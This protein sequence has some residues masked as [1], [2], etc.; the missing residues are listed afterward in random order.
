MKK[1]IK[2]GAV[3]IS[4]IMLSSVFG[5]SALA[6][7]KLL[8]H[9]KF[10]FKYA[11]EMTKY[12]NEYREMNGLK[13]LKTDFTLVE[14]AMIRAAECG[15]QFSHTRPNTK[16]WST[17]VD[18]EGA[19]AENIARGFSNPKEA[20]DA[21]YNSDGHRTNMLG[22]YTRVGV[23]VFTAD[24]GTNSWIH[25]FTRGS[26]KNSYESKE[27]RAVNVSIATDPDDN[28]TVQ[29][30]DGKDTPSKLAYNYE[31]SKAPDIK[32][33]EISDNELEY[34]GKNQAPEV[35]ARDKNGKK[36]ERR[37][38]KIILPKKHSD[39][40]TYKITV[41]HKYNGKTFSRKYKIVPKATSIT[42]L[43]K[44]KKYI[45]VR[46]KCAAMSVTG[47]KICYA[48]NKRFNNKKTITLKRNKTIK[49]SPG[50][51]KERRTTLR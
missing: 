45:T 30:C 19:V 29:Y 36:I 9:G 2:F 15:V 25:I 47:V 13:K 12:I 26:V 6:E 21:Y 5:I 23:G 51:R 17:V 28:T 33:V 39:F 4:L 40:G 42:S 31:K 27:V 10:N 50:L 7:S 22:D 46:W 41:E 3:L 16:K 38:Y 8:V 34:N 11:A 18:W 37:Y 43:S 49:K 32:T 20:T 1:L 35:I 14:P 48:K 44:S 24:D